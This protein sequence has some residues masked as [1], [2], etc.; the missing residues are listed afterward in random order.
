MMLILLRKLASFLFLLVIYLVLKNVGAG[1]EV[2]HGWNA[3]HPLTIQPHEL[4]IV[5]FDSRP[6]N[7]YWQTSQRWNSQYCRKYGHHYQFF[8]SRLPCRACSSENIAEPWCKV[9]AM[10]LADLSAA[11]S[12]KA[13]LYIDSDAMITVN[14]SMSTVISYIQHDLKWNSFEKPV[15]FNQDGP[16]FACKRAIGLG[17]RKCF[18]SG[19]VLWFRNPVATD[20]LRKWWMAGSVAFSQMTSMSKFP[21]NWKYKVPIFVQQLVRNTLSYQASLNSGHGSKQYST[22]YTTS[23]PIA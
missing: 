22:S 8:S 12:I 11:H 13:I 5:Q 7:D 2:L 3:T 17:Y 10:L 19:S 9:K 6:L 18:N 1:H 23:M 15:A 14:H 16:G 20:L 21:M 4:L